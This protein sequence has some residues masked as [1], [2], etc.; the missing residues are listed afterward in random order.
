MKTIN[1]EIDCLGSYCA[2][3]EYRDY[4]ETCR[5]YHYECAIFDHEDL[6]HYKD[7]TG[8]NIVSRC[9]QCLDGDGRGRGQMKRDEK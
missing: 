6:E 2:A 8:E 4:I 5:G 1:V 7:E 9:K 3:C